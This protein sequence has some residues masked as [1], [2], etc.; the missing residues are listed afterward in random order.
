MKNVFFVAI[1]FALA[2]TISA[3]NSLPSISWAR[4]DTI[5][6]LTTRYP[7]HKFT[8]DS[9]FG[10][11]KSYKVIEGREPTTTATTFV[12]GIDGRLTTIIYRKTGAALDVY[13]LLFEK[14]KSIYGNPK[15]NNEYGI[16]Q[17]QTQLNG[18]LCFTGDCSF[19]NSKG[20]VSIMIVASDSKNLPYVLLTETYKY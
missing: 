8:L 7:N 6:T 18:F 11:V 20:S 17:Y 1:F 9:S 16:N 12:F 13:E 14:Y 4:G 3:Q 5:Q 15:E 10:S 19:E 2:I